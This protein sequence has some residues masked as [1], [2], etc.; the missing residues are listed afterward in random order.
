MRTKLTLLNAL[1]S[2]VNMAISSILSLLM[3]RVVLVYL[4]SDY[5]GLNSTISQF[6]S[7]LM[8][9]ESGFTLA[10]LVKLFKPYDQ[11]DYAEVNRILSKSRKVLMRI[12]I[13]MLLVGTGCAAV[14]A[15]FIHSNVKY[16]VIV[17]MFFFSVAATAFNFAYT[18]KFRLVYQLTQQEYIIHI[19]SLV[20]YMVMYYGM[21][22]IV[23]YAK[24]I[25]YA[26]AFYLL[27]NILGGMAI[28]LIAKH[29][30]SFVSFHAPCEDVRVDGTK[31]LFVSKIVGVLYS[32]LTVFYMSIFVGTVQTSVYAVYNSVVSIISNFAN[33]TLMAP[34]NSLGQIINT[35]KGH[36]KDII[37]EYEYTTILVAAILFSTTL[38]LIMPFV[39][40][41]TAQIN[42]ANYIQPNIAILLVLISVLQIIHIPSGRCIELSGDFSAVKKIQLTTFV[43]LALLSILG[44]WL[45]G[46]IGLLMAKLITNIILA[47]MEIYYAH[48]VILESN[49]SGYLRILLPNMTIVCLITFFEYRILCDVSVNLLTFLCYGMILVVF[50]SLL[51]L[52]F[53]KLCYKD[54]MNEIL[55]RYRKY[56]HFSK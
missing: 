25:V 18:Y 28:R 55:Y 50:N 4:G 3:T 51:I 23:R 53:G 9:F 15:L 11:R 10:A 43:L 56:L 52:M 40:L 24:N 47:T 44:A 12:G 33:T 48:T 30:F 22:L 34:Q 1:F 20:Q 37:R 26:R 31:D 39:R 2:I 29:K 27:I 7:V 36:A 35:E 6:L 14:Y 16:A 41:Y 19:V 42:D 45:F 38:A 49:V 8:L 54:Q 46:L 32:S 21:M 5:N 17:A 13:A